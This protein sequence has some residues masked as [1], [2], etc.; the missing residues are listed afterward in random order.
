[1]ATVGGKICLKN[2]VIIL[3]IRKMKM[4]IRFGFFVLWH[5]NVRGL[6][7]AKAIFVEVVLLF[8]PSVG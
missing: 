1:M 3:I 8:N 4:K 2:Q 7:N 6:F 5:I